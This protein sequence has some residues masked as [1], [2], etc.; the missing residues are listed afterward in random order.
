MS[1][2]SNFIL[3][4]IHGGRYANKHSV[5]PQIQH[6]SAKKPTPVIEI[7]PP[8]K[9]EKV[10]NDSK[11]VQIVPDIRTSSHG[12]LHI[13][14]FTRIDRTNNLI[15]YENCITLGG[16]CTE[17]NQVCLIYPG[18]YLLSFSS[19]ISSGVPEARVQLSIETTEEITMNPPYI[20]MMIPSNR[21]LKGYAF[22][23]STSENALFRLRVNIEGSITLDTGFVHISSI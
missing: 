1:S 9:K 12:I 22:L 7:Q 15:S 21:F 10:E 4:G 11:V 17:D 5:T 14:P 18:V 13:T 16:Y 20:S 2:R 19:C 6:E 8:I 3:Q 23:T